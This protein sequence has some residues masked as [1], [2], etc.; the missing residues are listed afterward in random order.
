ML[1]LRSQG[2]NGKQSKAPEVMSLELKGPCLALEL[3]GLLK[4]H[5]PFAKSPSGN[6]SFAL[7][8][9]LNCTYFG[10]KEKP[11]IKVLDLL[12]RVPCRHPGIVLS[13]RH[14]HMQELTCTCS[15]D[16]HFQAE[17]LMQRR[18]F[19]PWT[20]K[21]KD[22]WW[23]THSQVKR[24]KIPQNAIPARPAA[25]MQV[26]CVQVNFGSFALLPGVQETMRGKQQSSLGPAWGRGSTIC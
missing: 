16:S 10:N 11:G 3:V 22:S 17:W 18:A 21:G 2:D 23:M 9:H 14:L 13:R 19:L 5:F 4:S 24:G 1:C 20:P 6:D 25:Q 7:N 15:L 12:I 8:I 26:H